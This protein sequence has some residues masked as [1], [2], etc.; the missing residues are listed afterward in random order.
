MRVKLQNSEDPT[1]ATQLT[2]LTKP[3]QLI[4]PWA[5][6]AAGTNVTSLNLEIKHSKQ[7]RLLEKPKIAKANTVV[8]TPRIKSKD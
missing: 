1:L 6:S 5:T 3:T 7:T 8:S 4:S 2:F